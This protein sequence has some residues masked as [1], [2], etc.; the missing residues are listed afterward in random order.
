VIENLTSR[1]KLIDTLGTERAKWEGLLRQVGPDRMELRGVT[2]EWSV[3]D[4]VAHVAAWERRP[5]AWLQ[6]IQ[7]VMWPQPPEWPTN[8]DEDGIN[9]WIFAANRGRQ[10]PDVL[11]ES[12]HV[13]DQLVQALELIKDQ[14][15][16]AVGRFEWLGGNS[17]G[18][19][20]AGNSFEHYQV[21]GEAIRAWLTQR[22]TVI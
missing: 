18:A 9:A 1:Q 11:N 8:L 19:S 3:K 6:A 16:T 15:L 5:V 21:H 12:R 2:G 14:D 20:I 22:E 7:T 4:I 17:L 13:F 10:V